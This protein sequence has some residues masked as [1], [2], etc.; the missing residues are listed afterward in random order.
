MRHDRPCRPRRRPLA[1][2]DESR[3]NGGIRTSGQARPDHPAEDPPPWNRRHGQRRG[4]LRKPAGPRHPR[5]RGCGQQ[6]CRWRECRWPARRWRECGWR[7]CRSGILGR[8][9]AAWP[10]RGRGSGPASAGAGLDLA[11][12]ERTSRPGDGSRGAGKL[13]YG[14]L[15]MGGNR[16]QPGA[17]PAA[18]AHSARRS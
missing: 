9:A 14:A 16:N 15:V 10:Y 18:P 13:A 17:G 1:S 11:V 7:E 4:T 6:G 5:C 2:R 12:A 8:W 3:C